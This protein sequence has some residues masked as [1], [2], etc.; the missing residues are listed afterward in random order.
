M[1]DP[2]SF[3]QYKFAPFQSGMG[4][5]NPSTDYSNP[6]KGGSRKSKKIH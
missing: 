2:T 6:Q 3:P 1:S 5:C 4:M